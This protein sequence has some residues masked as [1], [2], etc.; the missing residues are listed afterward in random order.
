MEYPFADTEFEL[1][2]ALLRD[3]VLEVAYLPEPN[4]FE[5][6]TTPLPDLGAFGVLP[7]WTP[8]PRPAWELALPDWT[9]PPAPTRPAALP[10]WDSL[11]HC[12]PVAKANRTH[13]PCCLCKSACT[14]AYCGCVKRGVACEKA[15]MHADCVNTAAPTRS[16][17]SYCTCKKSGCLKKYCVCFTAGRACGAACRCTSCVREAPLPKM[18]GPPKSAGP[19]TPKKR[20][21]CP[22]PRAATP[23][24]SAPTPVSASVSPDPAKRLRRPVLKYE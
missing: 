15:C 3:D 18:P 8:T 4:L 7:T 10:R 22:K 20:V 5:R 1:R 2:G 12:F 11:M 14:K 16:R 6:C 9:D 21:R 23:P 13:P 24:T 17:Q 19:R